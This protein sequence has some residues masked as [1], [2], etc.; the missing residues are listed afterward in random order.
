MVHARVS[1]EYIHFSLIHT[2]DHI[3]PILPIKK[4]VNQDVERTA[5]H[6]LTTDMK[7]SVSNLRVLFCSCA[8]RKAT[9]HAD[10]KALNM[11][12]QSQKGF[13]G[14]FVGIP[15]HQKGYLI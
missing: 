10:T 6:K 2:T 15:Q 5:P 13:S 3:F 9:A 12:H 1:E 4:L 11:C 8:L 14:I 7:P